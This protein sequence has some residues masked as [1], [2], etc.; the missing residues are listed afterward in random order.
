MKKLTVLSSFVIKIIA[1]ILM[2][3]DHIGLALV[4]FFPYDMNVIMPSNILRGFGR[5]ALPLFIFLIVEGVIHTKNIKKYFLRL[6]IMASIISTFLI[7]VTY[8]DFGVNLVSLQGFGNVFIDL[9]LAALAVY[10][11]KQNN[12]YLRLLVLLPLGISIISFAIKSYEFATGAAVL[13][14]PNWLYLQYDWFSI[15]LAI[16]FYLSYKAANLY[17]DNVSITRG[18]DKSIWEANGNYR[19]LVNLF[20]CLVIIVSSILFYLYKYAWPE[21]TFWD[22]NLQLFSL[23]SGAF[24]LLYNGKRGYNAKWFQYGSYPFY[25][26]H[27]LIIILICTLISG[28]I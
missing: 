6:G 25:I 14:Y 19:F 8:V 13:W 3:C 28:G 4:T 26:V 17:I 1:F 24:I 15:V 10:F 23:F 12:K 18:I 2:I 9:L 16:G 27:L 5:L 20:S 21:G 11:L 22:A 7:I